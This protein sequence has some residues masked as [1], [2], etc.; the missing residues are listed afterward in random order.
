MVNICYC[1][2]AFWVWGGGFLAEMGVKDFAG[3]IVV[4]TT[5]GLAALVVALVLGKEETSAPTQWYHHT[6]LYSQ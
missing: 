2:V 1:P 3:G 5:A 4:H 6:V